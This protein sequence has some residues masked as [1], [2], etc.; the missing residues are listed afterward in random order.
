MLDIKFIR[1]NTDIVKKDLERRKD[2]EKLKMVD[3]L[4]EK[5]KEYRE[6][7]QAEQELRHKRNDLT[8]IITVAV[9]KRFINDIRSIERGIKRMK[10]E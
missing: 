5:D 4:L 7:L 3:E 10:N 9:E 8:A 1:E 6:L 2:E